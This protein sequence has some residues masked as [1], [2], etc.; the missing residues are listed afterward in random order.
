MAEEI[1]TEHVQNNEI[2]PVT[3]RSLNFMSLSREVR[4]EIYKVALVSSSMI[5]VWK[6]GWVHKSEV[7]PDGVW[8]RIIVRSA[9]KISLSA[10]CTNMVLC[11]KIIGK[12]AAEIFYNKN[13][14]TFMG[15]HNW[16]P[17]VTWL[18]RIGSGNRAYLSN[19]EIEAYK[20][21][22]V[23]QKYNGE[24]VEHPD[25]YYPTRE[26]MYPRSPHLHLRSQPCKYGLVEN[27]NPEL[28]T[29]FRLLGEGTSTKT[30][31]FNFMLPIEYPGQGAIVDDEDQHPEY[32]WH[33]T[34]LPNLIEKF[35]TL[36]MPASSDSSKPRAQVLWR[37]QHPNV[38]KQAVGG[39]AVILDHVDNIEDH[40]WELE[41]L[42]N[43]EDDIEQ[44]SNDRRQDI[45]TYVLRRK[46]LGEPLLADD[47]NP[48]SG[49]W[50][51][52]QWRS[53]IWRRKT[54]L[55][56]LSFSSIKQSSHMI[57]SYRFR[58]SVFVPSNACIE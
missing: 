16:D 25:N 11:S 6:G 51:Q 2:Q 53:S 8:P 57:C 15:H 58:L 19:L 36:Y 48:Y 42:Q 1:Y 43:N 30:I 23:W 55:S 3:R 44:K 22:E 54:F 20:P 56:I 29:T 32:R 40:G 37:G 39:G 38:W 49:L 12:E 31:Q 24:R 5:V 46:P 18:R 34:D 41:I 9:T 17:I 50:I 35:R 14:F 28:E 4:D 26:P 10:L 21:I 52:P 45:P 47:P 13:T 7:N 33:G 27:I